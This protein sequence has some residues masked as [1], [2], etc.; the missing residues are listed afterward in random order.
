M[1]TPV[2]N[3]PFIAVDPWIR[4]DQASEKVQRTFQA[5]IASNSPQS[6]SQK[7]VIKVAVA[8]VTTAVAA[9]VM[10]ST[11]W[12]LNIPHSNPG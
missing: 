7:C 6:C 10:I 2:T 12:P 4:T 9:A 11:G 8:T 3:Q 1:A 5:K